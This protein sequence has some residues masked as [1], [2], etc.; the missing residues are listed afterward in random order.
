MKQD[1]YFDIRR[2]HV[3]RR[4][5]PAI[6]DNTRNEREARRI[7]KRVREEHPKQRFILVRRDPHE[8]VIG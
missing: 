5:V 3:G 7:L 1:G 2:T 4:K 8:V 6:I